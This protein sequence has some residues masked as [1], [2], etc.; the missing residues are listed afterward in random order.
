[1][2]RYTDPVSSLP[3]YGLCAGAKQARS[4]GKEQSFLTSEA[5]TPTPTDP[6]SPLHP[7]K[8][9]KYV[10]LRCVP[11]V[12]VLSWNPEKSMVYKGLSFTLG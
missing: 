3:I 2:G 7:Q 6:H 9:I 4:A 8:F 1:M 5:T 10:D 11:R 12:T